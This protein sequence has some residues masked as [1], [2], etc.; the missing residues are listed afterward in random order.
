MWL[1]LPFA[2]VSR[3]VEQNVHTTFSFTNPL[4]GSKELQSWG[5]SKI[6]LSFL[7]WVDGHFWPN[8]QQ[9]QRLPQY[10]SILDVHLS[11]HLLPASF[12]LKIENTTRKHL[13]SSEPHFHKPF[14]PILGFLSQIDQL[15]N[16]ILWQLS[17]HFCHPWHLKKWLYRTSYNLYT[18]ED[19]QTK[20]GVWTDVGW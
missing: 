16:K 17:V 3:S 1:N 2:Q 5:C 7:M 13:I 6:L 12:H 10:E 19:K 4:S 18:V 8:Q 9:Q 20:L 14:A 11:R 15:W